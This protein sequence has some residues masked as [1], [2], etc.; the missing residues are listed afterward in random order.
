[1]GK[2]DGFGS[3]SLWFR[4]FY[5]ETREPEADPRFCSARGD[6][7]DEGRVLAEG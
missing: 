5:R 2:V 1:M 4:L 6:G 3:F 7:I